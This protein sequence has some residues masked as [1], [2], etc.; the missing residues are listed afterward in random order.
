MSRLKKITRFIF[1]L[2]LIAGGLGGIYG[3]DDVAERLSVNATNKDYVISMSIF[4]G[5]GF[6]AVWAVYWLVSFVFKG[7]RD[8]D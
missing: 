3:H 1:V 2:S 8:T 4:G 5:L 6:A 7:F